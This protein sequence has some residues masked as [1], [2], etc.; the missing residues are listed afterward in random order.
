MRR[1]RTT[2]P[3]LTRNCVHAGLGRCLEAAFSFILISSDA[4]VIY[5][6]IIG[7]IIPKVLA[8]GAKE[9]EKKSRSLRLSV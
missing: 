4:V 9:K 2:R 8:W 1:K 7:I 6:F 5:R 3:K